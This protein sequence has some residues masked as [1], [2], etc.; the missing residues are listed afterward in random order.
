MNHIKMQDS[1]LF[2]AIQNELDW[3][4]TKIKYG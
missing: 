3:Q 2:K 1:K 4:R